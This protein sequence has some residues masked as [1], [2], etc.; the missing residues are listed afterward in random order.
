MRVDPFGK[1]ASAFQRALLD[2]VAVTQ[3]HRVK[4]FVS[5]QRDGVAGHHV[6]AVQEIGDAAKALSLTLG[7]EGA[8][9]DVQAHQLGVFFRVAGGE[10]FQIEGVRTFGQILQHELVAVHLERGTTA[11]H[12]HAGQI[13][14]FAVQ[15][16]R[17][18]RHVGVAAQAHFA[19]HA[20]FGR[21][22][23]ERQIDRVDPESRG[24]ISLP[25][26]RGGL[27]FTHH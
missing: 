27:S 17:L 18:G 15:A 25:V 3:Q 23:V 24:S 14:V 16:Q 6:R 26:N 5:A 8:L 9:A 2:Q 11:V 21:V 12:Q 7:E 13:E 1:V 4:G 10:N 20:G 19:Q 22:E